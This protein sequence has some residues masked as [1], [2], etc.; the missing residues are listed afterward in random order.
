MK[1]LII[2]LMLLAMPA[3]AEEPALIMK[4]G[5]D[6]RATLTWSDKAG[7]PINLTGNSYAAQFRSA[8]GGAL[9][10]TYS[11]VVTDA[12]KGQLQLRLSRAQTATL[13]GKSGVWDLRETSAAGVVTYQLGGT[14][15]VLPTVTTP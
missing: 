10:A 14:A 2:I 4:A 12:P 15:K 13:S 3:L 7:K 9:F 6:F 11:C 1:R 5:G 8:T